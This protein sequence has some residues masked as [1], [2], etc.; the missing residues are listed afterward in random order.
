MTRAVRFAAVGLA[1]AALQLALFRTLCY[2]GVAAAPATALAVELVILNN[3]YWH[4]RITWK[5]RGA[6]H[7]RNRARRLLRF[8]AAN[9]LVSLAGN[10]ALVAILTQ[11]ISPLPA[12][13][14]AIA[15]CA[16]LNYLLADRCVFLN[17]IN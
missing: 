15:L 13:A 4:Q 8:H 10:T 7:L 1:G 12:A 14:A 5:D 17:P 11:T 9:G 6:P 16:P 2:C 3:F